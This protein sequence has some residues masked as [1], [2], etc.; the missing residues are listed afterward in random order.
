MRE[1]IQENTELSAFTRP[2]NPVFYSISEGP[3]PD[4]PSEDS[5]KKSKF[6]S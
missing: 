2:A 4:E 6:I 5:K 1:K 3:P